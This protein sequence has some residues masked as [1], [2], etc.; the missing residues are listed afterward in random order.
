MKHIYLMKLKLVKVCA[1][2]ITSIWDTRLIS[3]EL[4]QE[5]FPLPHLQAT[6]AWLLVLNRLELADSFSL[7][8]VIV[9]KSF[10]II[11]VKLE[12]H[13]AIKLLAQGK[14]DSTANVISK[15]MHN[16]FLSPIE[17]H[18]VL[19]VPIEKYRKFKARYHRLI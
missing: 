18:K 1:N 12:K 14:L 8:T 3:S 16:G 19:K 4:L 10:E 6:L 9:R 13:N 5:G 15:A 2:T 11:A 17:F 7:A